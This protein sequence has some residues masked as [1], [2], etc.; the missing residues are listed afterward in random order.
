MGGLGELKVCADAIGYYEEPPPLLRNAIVAG[1]EDPEGGFIPGPPEGS[2]DVVECS[3]GGMRHQSGNIL[4]YNELRADSLK[5]EANIV[6]K[7][8]IARVA[9]VSAWRI[10]REALTGWSA[11]QDIQLTTLCT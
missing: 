1:I 9:L 6:T 5:Y 4:E 3:P 8:V 7:K 11:N 2:T 10:D